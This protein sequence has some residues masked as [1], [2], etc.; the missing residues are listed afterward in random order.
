MNLV[1]FILGT[2][3]QYKLFIFKFLILILYPNIYNKI[4]LMQGVTIM[5]VAFVM[6]AWQLA[7]DYHEANNMQCLCVLVNSYC[8]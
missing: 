5:G 2:T 4:L 8:I 1:L 7:L 3:T 6:T